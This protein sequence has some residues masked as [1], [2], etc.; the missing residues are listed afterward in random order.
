MT[1]ERRLSGLGHVAPKQ[2]QT[3]AGLDLPFVPINVRGN[4]VFVAGYPNP[5][6]HEVGLLPPNHITTI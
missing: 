3:S 6:P 5:L 2:T 1:P 4:R